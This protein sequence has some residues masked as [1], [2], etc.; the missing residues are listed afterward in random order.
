[1]RLEERQDYLRCDFCGRFHFP[2]PDADGVR[3]LGATTAARCSLCSRELVHAAVGGVR[4]LHCVSCLG[5]L[6][7]SEDFLFVLE[8]LRG[9]GSGAGP[10]AR[11][12]NFTE[13][14][15]R[16]RC[17]QCNDWMHTHAYAGAGN[18]VI[19]NCPHCRVNWLDHG[20]LRRVA[21]AAAAQYTAHE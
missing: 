4:V 8:R 2:E 10:P 21:S 15:R 3:V 9:A 20:E 18:I 6:I 11:P 13:L 7:P 17:P 1:M 12:L 16:L 5:L 14:E 19:D